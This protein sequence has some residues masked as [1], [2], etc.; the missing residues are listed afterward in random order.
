MSEI[1]QITVNRFNEIVK[2]TKSS[3]NLAINYCEQS[4]L[5]VVN[6]FLHRYQYFL[7]LSNLKHLNIIC[8]C[9]KPILKYVY[10]QRILNLPD[11][12]D[13]KNS[14]DMIFWIEIAEIRLFENPEL[15]TFLWLSIY[16]I[17]LGVIIW[18]FKILVFQ[19]QFTKIRKIRMKKIKGC[20]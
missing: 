14:N 10:C 17:W 12:N 5:N 20:F 6:G 15:K 11:R 19:I 8:Y 18:K 13:Y 2:N 1:P 16:E 9:T 3:T 4:F 7:F